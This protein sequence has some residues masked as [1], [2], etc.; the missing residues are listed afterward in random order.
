MGTTTREWKK[1]MFT[2]KPGGPKP[3]SSRWAAVKSIAVALLMF[4]S[5][6]S[7]ELGKAQN[8]CKS[9]EEAVFSCGVRNDRVVSICRATRVNPN[10]LTYRFG[11]PHAI[12]LEH[13]DATGPESSFFYGGYSRYLTRYFEL[14]FKKG[15][16]T[17][18]I[19]YRTSDDEPDPSYTLTV[20]LPGDAERSINFDCQKSIQ[21]KNLTLTRD[22]SCSTTDAIGC[23]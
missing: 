11:T 21:A 6:L 16:Y 23:E 14:G 3:E 18:V 9:D 2:S 1:T 13:S 17:Y 19:S 4:A 20:T 15:G 12:E 10:M 7:P 5:G 22:V 8:L